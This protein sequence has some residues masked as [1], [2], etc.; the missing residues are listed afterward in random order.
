MKYL[1]FSLFPLL[2]A[3]NLVGSGTSEDGQN[4]AP[5][6]LI[7]GSESGVTFINS[8]EDRED[9]NVLTYRNYYNGGGVA[10]GDIN[11]DG[12]NDIFFTANM[13]SNKLYLNKGDMKF[14]EISKSAGVSGKA[15][16]STGVTFADV[17][18]DGYMD[19]YVCSSGD[20]VKEN[21]E[22]ELYIN[23]G[24]LTFSERASEFGL[25]DSG[26]STHAAFF[27][28]DLDGDLDCFVLNN[29]YKDPE[30]ISLI[31]RNRFN[32]NSPGG[33]RLYRN[34]NGHFTNITGKFE[35]MNLLQIQ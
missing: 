25:N 7:S 1:V 2:L 29:S 12:L 3:C 9:F 22:N 30:R 32:Y 5:F 23:N 11:N 19:I 21:K 10:I 28:Y 33:D 24:D 8:V 26:L 18:A 34:D 14:E 16:W 35:E 20:A 15:S 6:R 13:S 27:D 31:S 17:N 4:E